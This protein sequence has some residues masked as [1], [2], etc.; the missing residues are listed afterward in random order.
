MFPFSSHMIILS[1]SPSREIP[2]LALYFFT[3]DLI[4][5]GNVDPQLS[6]IFNPFGFIPIAITFAPKRF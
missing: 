2:M 4:L 5:F 3:A 1:A 6:L